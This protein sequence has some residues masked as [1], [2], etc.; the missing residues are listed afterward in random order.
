M[1]YTPCE[2][3]HSVAPKLRMRLRGDKTGNRQVTVDIEHY[4]ALRLLTDR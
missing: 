2:L 4:A 3:L 1:T